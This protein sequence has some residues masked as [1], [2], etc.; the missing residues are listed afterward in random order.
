MKYPLEELKN[1]SIG[2]AAE[3]TKITEM[4][5][6][7]VILENSLAVSYTLSIYLLYYPII[8]LLVNKFIQ[9]K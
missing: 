6:S 7:I 9:V 3:D 2:S 5:N 8:P 1:D 4:Q